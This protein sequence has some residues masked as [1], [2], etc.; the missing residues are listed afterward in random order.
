LFCR[1]RWPF[2]EV[3]MLATFGDVA[4]HEPGHR[5][6]PTVRLNGNRNRPSSIGHSPRGK[7]ALG[8][9]PA[10]WSSSK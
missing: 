1:F 6:H 4:P 10:G 9:L 5:C 7:P 8:Q 2:G 3:Q